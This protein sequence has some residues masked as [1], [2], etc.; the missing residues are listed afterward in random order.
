MTD[1]DKGLSLKQRRLIAA[2]IASRTQAEAVAKVGIARRTA[3]RWMTLPAFREALQ[4]A[5]RDLDR[6]TLDAT[7]RRL[8]EGLPQALDVLADVMAR[9]KANE[10][11]QAADS[12]IDATQQLRDITAVDDRLAELER[13]LP[14]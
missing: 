3:S 10:R 1:G 2:L 6:Q 13:T 4:A 7:S 11:R 8:M 5:L 14:K 12:W 9:G